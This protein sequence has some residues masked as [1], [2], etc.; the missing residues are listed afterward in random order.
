MYPKSLMCMQYILKLNPFC[1]IVET[2]VSSLWMAQDGSMYAHFT[3]SPSQNP[4]LYTI[5]GCET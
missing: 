5:L 2:K 4:P 3:V 1:Y